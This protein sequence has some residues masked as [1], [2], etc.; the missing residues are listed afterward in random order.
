MNFDELKLHPENFLYNLITDAARAE[1][2]LDQILEN[3]KVM[4]ER[5]N[6]RESETEQLRIEHHDLKNE[7]IA[8]KSELQTA[9]ANNW[10]WIIAVGTLAAGIGATAGIFI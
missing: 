10:K 9:Q 7:V 6:K 1:Q 3:Q 2:K 8:I 4:T 5:I